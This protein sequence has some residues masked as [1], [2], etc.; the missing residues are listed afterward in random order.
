MSRTIELAGHILDHIGN[1]AEAEVLVTGGESA[2]TRFANSFIHQNVAEEGHEVML[3]V[4]V[5]GRV[6]SAATTSIKGIEKFVDDTIEACQQKIAAKHGFAIKDHSLII[7]GNCVKENCP[8]LPA[9]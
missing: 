2:L 4:A 3:R 6:N 5:G 8:H 9:D 1:R 7:Y